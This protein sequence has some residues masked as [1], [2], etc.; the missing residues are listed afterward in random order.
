MRYLK[1]LYTHWQCS[2]HPYSVVGHKTVTHD[3][4]ES[5]LNIGYIVSF[6]KSYLGRGH[7]FVPFVLPLGIGICVVS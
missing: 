5:V 7:F 4:W 1:Y 2:L 6:F 3:I